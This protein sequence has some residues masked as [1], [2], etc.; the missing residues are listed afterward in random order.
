MK[1]LIRKA[2]FLISVNYY[3]ILTPAH[4]NGL[5]IFIYWIAG[6]EAEEE[7]TGQL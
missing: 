1:F 6:A 2:S 4:L 3:T 7:M 5:Y